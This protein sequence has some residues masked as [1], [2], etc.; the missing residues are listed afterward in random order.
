MRTTKLIYYLKNKYN[1]DSDNINTFF[2]K[3]I[4]ALYMHAFRSKN[5]ELLNRAKQKQ[6]EWE[7]NDNIKLVITKFI[8]SNCITWNFIL[9]IRKVFCLLKRCFS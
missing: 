8:M 6:K 7:I 4:F 1:I 2:K 3:K 5:K 9:R